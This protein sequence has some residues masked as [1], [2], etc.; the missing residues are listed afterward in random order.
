MAANLSH[1]AS[2]AFVGRC[3]YETPTCMRILSP[4]EV[5][6]IVVDVPALLFHAS[7]LFFIMRQIS[8]KKEDF[9]SAFYRLFVAMSVVEAIHMVDVSI[10]GH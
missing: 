1:V 6:L 7:M 10:H 4:V 5:L 3:P 8:R 9:S 2:V